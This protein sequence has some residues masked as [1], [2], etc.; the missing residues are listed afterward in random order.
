MFTFNDVNC[1]SWYILMSNFSSEKFDMLETNAHKWKCECSFISLL[2]CYSESVCI[3]L[4][5]TIHRFKIVFFLCF[6]AFACR[7]VARN[8]R[9]QIERAVLKTFLSIKCPASFRWALSWKNAD[10]CHIYTINICMVS[11]H[12]G[13]YD[14]LGCV[15][16]DCFHFGAS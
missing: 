9:E 12:S 10:I 11:P 2:V 16:H 13:N 7:L 4:L 8:L 14:T 5:T 3:F 6:I 1:V 15:T